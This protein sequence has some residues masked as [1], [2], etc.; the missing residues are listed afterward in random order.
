MILYL[1]YLVIRINGL[2]FKVFIK[3]LGVFCSVKYLI[4]ER[5]KEMENLEDRNYVYIVYRL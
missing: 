2:N 1:I 5:R 3:V 4:I